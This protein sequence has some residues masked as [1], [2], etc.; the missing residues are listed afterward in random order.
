MTDAYG[1][2]PVQNPKDA[3]VGF[4]DTDKR[5]WRFAECYANSFG[6]A[7]SVFNYTRYMRS[8][9]FLCRKVFALL[10]RD[11]IDDLCGFDRARC[12]PQASALLAFLLSRFGAV[13]A[14]KTFVGQNITILGL[15]YDL[16]L[17]YVMYV[18]CPFE[19]REK[20]HDL[21]GTMIAK[22]AQNIDI[23]MGDLDAL[24]GLGDHVFCSLEFC[25]GKHEYTGLCNFLE[26]TDDDFAIVKFKS[27]EKRNGLHS[28]P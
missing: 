24:L 23:L 14:D 20:L 22:L 16:F 8:L 7:R 1:H 4:Y 26:K 18:E 13:S 3:L 11:Y 6:N 25:D 2:L 12:A 5:K 15:Q 28:R 27:P 10:V 21:A 19:K 17:K 9:T